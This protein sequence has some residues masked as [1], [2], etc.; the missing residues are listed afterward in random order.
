MFSHA[1][2]KHVACKALRKK[3]QVFFAMSG[4]VASRALPLE[5]AFARVSQEAGARARPRSPAP[6]LH[7]R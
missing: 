1:F 3:N 6:A 2:F 5:R 4:V 7:A